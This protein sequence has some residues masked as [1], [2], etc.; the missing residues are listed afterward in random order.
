MAAAPPIDIGPLLEAFFQKK[1]VALSRLISLVENRPTDTLPLLTTL[2]PNTG[3][4]HVIG[5]T[6]PPGAGKS[7]LVNALVERM[8]GEG[9]SVAVVAVDPSSPF[10]GGA[11]LGDRIR[12]LSHAVDDGVFIR[13]LSTRGALGGLSRAT[14][15][16]VTLFDAYGFDK[17][18][19]ETVG[20]GQTE[21]QILELAHTT[22]VVLVPEAGDSIQTQKAGILEVADIFVVNKADR[23][24]AERMAHNLE[25]SLHLGVEKAWPVPV[26]LS[27]ARPEDGYC[28]VPELAE[29]MNAHFA[30]LR[31]HPAGKA[32]LAQSRK[33]QWRRLALEEIERQFD[34]LFG[35]NA[36]L[37]DCLR[38]A[39]GLETNPYLLL[40]SFFEI[41][42]R[43]LRD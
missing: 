14:R 13:S 7:T 41:L 5:I 39:E 23:S 28:G 43:R 31:E 6:G 34:G 1:T 16:V 12:M 38:K 32:L 2:Y 42:E 8:R 22:V 15:A 3:R 19:V 36:Q 33:G 11:I 21:F 18:I 17:V 20:V 9:K 24:G 4:A 37:I 25:E 26:I 10:S 27:K 40:E 30:F 35:G 29:K